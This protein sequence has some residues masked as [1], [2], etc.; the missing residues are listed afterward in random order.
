MQFIYCISKTCKNTSQRPYLEALL[1]MNPVGISFT[2]SPTTC[3]MIPVL[4]DDNSNYLVFCAFQFLVLFMLCLYFYFFTT[5]HSLRLKAKHF[6]IKSTNHVVMSFFK[7]HFSFYVISDVS[8]HSLARN[9]RVILFI[10][11]T[12]NEM[13]AVNQQMDEL[14]PFFVLL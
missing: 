13:R 9:E 5:I 14:Q 10:L 3:I 6:A 7:P 11:V 12:R 4:Y 8:L 2:W 1:F